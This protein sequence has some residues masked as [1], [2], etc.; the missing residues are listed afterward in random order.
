MFYQSILGGLLQ[1]ALPNSPAAQSNPPPLYPLETFF[2][3]PKQGFFRLSDNGNYLGFMQPVAVDDQPARMNIFIQP[4]SGSALQGQPKQ[5]TTE[6]ARDISAYMWKGDNT[7]LYEKDFKGDENFHVV[8]V[9]IHD[10]T[11]TDLTPYDGVRANLIDDLEDDPDH[12]LIS[13]NRRDAQV[14]DVFRVNVHTGKETK[15][16]ENPGNIISWSSDHQGRVLLAMASDGLNSELL[17]RANENEAFKSLIKTDFRTTVAPLFFDFDNIHFYALSNRERDTLALVRIHPQRPDEEE[18]VYGIDGYD[19][20]GASYSR[21]RQVLTMAYYQ[22]DKLAYHFFDDTSQKLYD[23]VKG[24]LPDFEISFQSSTHDESK[25]IVAAHND[26]T[27][28]SRYIY[29]VKADTLDKLADINPELKAEHMAAM[30]PISLQSRDGLTLHGYLTLP[31]G[32]GDKNLPLVVNP[33]GGPWARDS[34]GFNPE[35]QFLANRG[36]AVLQINFRGSTGYGRRFWEASFG[37]WGLSMQDDITD[38]VHWVVDQGIADA[39]RIA[40]Y[41]G[42]Y[43]GYAT[44]AGIVK[45]PNLYAAAIDYVGVS[46]LLTFLNTIPPYWKP[47]LEKM[48]YMVGHPERDRERLEA[49]SPALNA[50]KIRTPLLIAQGAHDPRVNK[51]ESDQMVEALRARG[52]DV[53]YIVKD[54]EGHG[55]HND[56]NKFEFYTRMEAFLA[57]HLKEN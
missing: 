8:A 42:S 23:T 31:L 24:H 10:G 49:T 40:I 14:F 3:N 20:S 57:T 35:V 9:N 12:I 16:A 36:Y 1:H 17:Y 15:V 26:K 44:L 34:W 37:Q 51:A 28:G 33:H 25:Y 7:I 32:R 55:F 6:S 4:L 47:M 19:L 21:H 2:R 52:I 22:T 56:E 45:T 54:N 30:Q 29:D 53:E 41:G 48:H 43:G 38:A 46:N 5:L 11:V 50:D 27:P 13:H 39:K 18:W